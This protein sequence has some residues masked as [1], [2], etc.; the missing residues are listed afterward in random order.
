MRRRGLAALGVVGLLVVL[1]AAPRGGAQADPAGGA[2]IAP[3]V[4][5]STRCVAFQ[6]FESVGNSR[7]VKAAAFATTVGPEN[8][9]SISESGDYGEATVWYWAPCG[10]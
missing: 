5:V 9:I 4:R 1:S 8:L 6:T 10:K 2:N 3:P 7:R